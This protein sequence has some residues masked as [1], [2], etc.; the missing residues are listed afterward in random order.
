VRGISRLLRIALWLMI[1]FAA[2]ITAACWAGSARAETRFAMLFTYPDG[3]RCEH[4]CLFGVQP[5]HT[6]FADALVLLRTHPFL[7]SLTPMFT[8]GNQIVFMGQGITVG[9]TSDIDGIAASLY[10]EL[11]SFNVKFD[12]PTATYSLDD[13]TLGDAV[14][15]LGT[16]DRLQLVNGM[17]GRLMRIYY[18]DSILILNHERIDPNNVTMYDP[19]IRLFLHSDYISVQPEMDA[20]TGFSSTGRYLHLY[21]NP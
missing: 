9:L 3:R 12:L 2:I 5:G 15:V 20:W 17:Y 7:E 1:A 10:L 4:A 6:T 13:V 19:F 16:P 14:N 8:E 21:S 11:S 18:V